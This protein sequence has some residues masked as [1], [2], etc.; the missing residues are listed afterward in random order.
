MSE[1]VDPDSIEEIVGATRHPLRHLA[2][3]VSGEE[4]VYVL[5]SMRCVS[6]G[7]D[8]R[9]CSYSRMLDV[10]ID[11]ARW[12]GFE[13]RAVVVHLSPGGL[14]PDRFAV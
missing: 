11:R 10:G 13:D 6:K 14:V 1:L 12:E 8:L 7:R 5:H 2:R 9:E 3:A 4:T